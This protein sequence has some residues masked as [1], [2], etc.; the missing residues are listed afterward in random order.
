MYFLK[1]EEL[2]DTAKWIADH[3]EEIFIWFCIACVIISVLFI[4]KLYFNRYKT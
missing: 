2:S 1:K 4:A 3:F